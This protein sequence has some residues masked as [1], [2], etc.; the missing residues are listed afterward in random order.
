MAL[1]DQLSGVSQTAWDDPANSLRHFKFLDGIVR[2]T[3]SRSRSAF[4]TQ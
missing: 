4:L 3:D 1:S 2:A